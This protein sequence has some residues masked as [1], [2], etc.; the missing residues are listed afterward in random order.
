[1]ISFELT[2]EQAEL[3]RTLQRYFDDHASVRRS[4]ELMEHGGGFDRDVWLQMA[5]E[6]GLQGLHM[7]E[8]YGGSGYGYVE[9]GVVLHAMGRVLYSGPFLASVVFATEAILLS[10]AGDGFAD[11]LRGVAGGTQ[12][13][14]LAVAEKSGLFT[15]DDIQTTAADSGDGWL[16]DGSKTLVLHGDVAT[17]LVVAARSSTGVSLFVVDADAPGLSKSTLPTMDQ[18]RS[19]ARVE[20]ASTPARLLGEE[21]GAWAVIESVLDRASVALACDALGVAD[22][23]LNLS[24]EY[25]KNRFQF[26]RAIGSFQAIKHKF[27]DMVVALELARSAVDYATRALDAGAEDATTAATI[28]LAQCAEASLAITGESIQIYGGIGFTWEHD[29][30]LYFKRARADGSLL[31]TVEEHRERMLRS[32]GV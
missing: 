19:L 10:G 4:R 32:L 2:D 18:T 15:A 14:A 8:E 3:A 1:V 6:L 7:P 31:G 25:A 23:S 20:F 11:L 22:E 28:A 16:V 26:G 27:A 30:H 17:F 21:G 24:V 12:I 13:G 29:A 9:L 5:S